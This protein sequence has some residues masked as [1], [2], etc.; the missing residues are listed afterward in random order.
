MCLKTKWAIIY[1]SLYKQPYSSLTFRFTVDIF[2]PSCFHLT[3]RQN[4]STTVFSV[5]FF[6]LGSFD[7]PLWTSV[8][9]L[10][11]RW[12]DKSPEPVMWFHYGVII[13]YSLSRPTLLSSARNNNKS[14]QQA[15]V[16]RWGKM[17]PNNHWEK[18]LY[19]SCHFLLYLLL[20]YSFSHQSFYHL[21]LFLFHSFFFSFFKSHTRTFTPS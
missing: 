19:S 7:P 21:A 1:N 16:W 8:V 3:S 20:L 5:C 2:S 17:S 13:L 15:C 4:L 18:H 11:Q 10:S 9:S 6:A 12:V 14:N